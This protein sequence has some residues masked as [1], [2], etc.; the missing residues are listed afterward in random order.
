MTTPSP[1]ESLYPPGRIPPGGTSAR[2]GLALPEVRYSVYTSRNLRHSLIAQHDIVNR[3]RICGGE[4]R[5]GGIQDP[6]IDGKKGEGCKC[7]AEASYEGNQG[8]LGEAA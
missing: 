8:V 7:R 3:G 1:R 4:E 5:T 6:K 2:L